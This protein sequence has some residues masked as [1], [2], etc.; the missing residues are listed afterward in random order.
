MMTFGILLYAAIAIFAFILGMYVIGTF[1]AV[2]AAILF[3]IDRK[4]TAYDNRY[5]NNIQTRL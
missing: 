3:V 2:V 5:I 4:R 1:A